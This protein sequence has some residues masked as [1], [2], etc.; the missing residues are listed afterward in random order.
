MKRDHIVI[1]GAREHNLKN[2]YVKI[3]KHEL[4]VITGPSGSGKSSLAFDT[5]FAEGQRR[6]VESL[7]AYARQF[8]GQME[9]PD[10]DYIRGLSPTISIEQKS[11]SN[12]PRSTVGTITEIFDYLRVL[13]ARVGEQRCPK[14]HQPV[15][16]MHS[17]QIVERILTFPDGCRF[18]VMSPVVR[19]RKGEFK[20]LFNELR[21][22]G[23]TRIR[24]NGEILLLSDIESLDKKNKHMVDVV[25]DRLVIKKGLKQR[26]TDS[27]ET[28]L[29]TGD[30]L[31]LIALLGDAPKEHLYSERLACHQCDLAFSELSPQ[32]FSFNSPLG[33][34]KGCNGLGTAL[35]MDEK[36][37]VD[38]SLSMDE[39]AVK[40]WARRY[41]RTQRLTWRIVKALVKEAGVTMQTPWNALPDSLQKLLIHGSGKKTFRLMIQGRKHPIK[42]GF[43]GALPYLMRRFHN[44]LNETVREHFARY[45]TT[46]KCDDC[47]GS[48]LRPESR[49]VVIS[50]KT[51]V[52]INAMT[53]ER[54]HSFFQ[55]LTLPGNRGVIAEEVLKEIQNRLQFLM[56]VGLSYLN[57]NRAGPSL[58]GGEAQRIRLASQLGCELTGV[59]YI[60]DEPSIGL[61]QR[62]NRQLLETLKSLRDLGNTVLVVEHDRETMENCDHII[63]FGPGAGRFGGDIVAEGEGR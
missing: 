25:I 28:A 46:S 53:I 33:M 52:D 41:T 50:D 51:L 14:C 63:D 19:N 23:F 34:C 47:C 17:S 35:L 61:H 22:S 29:K 55:Q 12:N 15:G 16:K 18:M 31:C 32:S 2:L 26:L 30:G 27:V 7:S 56:N 38:P 5:L 45:L 13:Y 44:A 58:S 39:G 6:Y 4:V 57:L 48:R 40:I 60:L 42:T 3:P 20:E 9:K 43:E 10:Y 21:S 8:L 62:D 59:L 24:H 49:S 37:V 1:K 36:K 11:A 54:V